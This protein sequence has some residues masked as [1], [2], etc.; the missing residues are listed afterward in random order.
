MIGETVLAIGN[1]QGHANTVT[2]GVLSATGR[3]IKAV[4][5]DGRAHEY[6]GLLQTD[7]AINPGNSGGALLDITGK[8]IGINNAMAVGAENIGF[9]IPI[10][11]V[12]EVFEK[13][14]LSSE[15]FAAA[16]DAAWLG[17]DIG[18]ANGT[19]VVK[20]VVPGGPAA[21][22]GVRQGDA[23]VGAGGDDVHTLL[24]YSRRLMSAAA[25]KPFALRLRRDGRELESR[26]RPLT[27]TT[28]AILAFT[29][30]EVEEVTADDDVELVRRAT[31]ALYRNRNVRRVPLLPAVLRVRGV[32]PGSPAADLTI[33]SGDILLATRLTSRFGDESDYPIDAA[34]FAGLLRSAQGGELRMVLLRGEALFDGGLE[35][36]RLDQR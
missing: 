12:R 29:G 24:E 35:V 2:R 1:P 6:S 25:G 19:L 15:G 34:T 7:A 13:E 21:I 33:Q 26:P 10:D 31:R 4:G 36:R 17:M 23:L 8:L 9:A 16:A 27:H 18:D 5:P 3:S 20:S 30:I 11:T 22:A 28:G 14:L 32:Q